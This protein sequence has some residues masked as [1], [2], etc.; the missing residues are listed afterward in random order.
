MASAG[1]VPPLDVTDGPLSTTANG[2]P[3]AGACSRTRGPAHSSVP[4]H[5][6]TSASTNPPE[7]SSATT[8]PARAICA[9]VR[10]PSCVAKSAGPKT[11]P[12][13]SVAKRTSP[14]SDVPGAPD[15]A[16][17]PLAV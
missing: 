15:V 8:E 16:E 12:S 4:R 1:K 6:D 17:Y 9:Q 7:V 3:V 2:P 11:Q 5:G 13:S 14:T 10:P